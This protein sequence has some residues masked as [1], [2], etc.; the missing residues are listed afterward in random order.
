MHSFNNTLIIQT[1][2]C[3]FVEVCLYML[4]ELVVSLEYCT[5]QTQMKQLHTVC[6]QAGVQLLELS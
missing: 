4:P 3:S 1:S 6:T 5:V 2:L